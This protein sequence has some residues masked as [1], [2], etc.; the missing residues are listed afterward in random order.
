MSKTWKVGILGCGDYL[1]WQAPALQASHSI[2]VA[3]LFDPDLKRAEKWAAELGGVAVARDAEI[4]E[5]PAID[6]VLLFVPPWIRRGLIE[7]AAAAGKTILTTKPLA[8][9]VDE[10]DAMIATVARTGV[11]CGVFYGRTGDNWFEAVKQLLDGGQYGRLALYRQDWLH[12]YPQWN[13]WALDPSKNGGPF[14]D[15]MIHNLNAA[16][17]LMGRPVLESTFTSARLAHTDIPCADTESMQ[18]RFEGGLA[19][20]FITWAADLEVMS[21][22]GNNREHI[23]H[24]YLV[25]DRGWHLTKQWKDGA[26]FIRASREG[27]VEL[28]PA[29]ALPATP[30]DRFVEAVASGAPN[31]GDIPTLEQARTDI[32]LIKES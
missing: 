25:T 15:A 28:I 3:K 14:M 22:D 12:H 18:V 9:S 11:R 2:K 27:R 17:Y 23:D 5:D 7:R 21:T 10:C 24:F 32:H 31:P 16:C 19:L 8:P 26:V 1:R 30:F 13:N 29:P 4:L 20:L 6:L